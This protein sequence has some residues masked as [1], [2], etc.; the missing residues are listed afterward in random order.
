MTQVQAQPDRRSRTAAS[1][2]PG[3]TIADD[4]LLTPR[5]IDARGFAEYASALRSLIEEAAEESG[6]L[7]TTREEVASLR[8]AIAASAGKL[9]EQLE[10]TLRV[11]PK[12]DEGATRV[13]RT[14]DRSSERAERAAA[15]EARLDTF[16]SEQTETIEAALQSGVARLDTHL[17]ELLERARTESI[18]VT[19]RV[20]S[21]ATELT[22]LATQAAER[23]R[24]AGAEIEQRVDRAGATCERL[25]R[26][27][28]SASEQA[29]ERAANVLCE[30]DERLTRVRDD[31]RREGDEAETR[32]QVSIAGAE[33]RAAAITT[34]VETAI[35]EAKGLR[36]LERI[37][38]LDALLQRADQACLSDAEGSLAQRLEQASGA[39]DAMV[40]ALGR[41]EE[42]VNVATNARRKLTDAIITSAKSI[43][44]LETRQRELDEGLSRVQVDGLE[45]ETR[46]AALETRL[47]DAAARGAELCERHATL[48]D[49]LRE[50][51]DLADRADTALASRTAELDAALRDPQ[52]RLEALVERAERAADRL[53][54]LQKKR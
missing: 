40:T 8:E 37:E 6:T 30:L 15:L 41:V 28:Q 4:L 10:A 9:R 42:A 44:K 36:V 31:L 14:L 21:G 32:V 26:T 24:S 23:A 47:N 43:D 16:A 18:A 7:R 20:Q 48:H 52:A 45:A 12:L 29:A 35:S 3:A 1:T 54:K 22:A 38:S 50:T 13:E 5:V 25:E 34:R 17:D 33:T 11:I 2:A 46:A 39:G 49:A 53:E 51:L 27:L 19:A